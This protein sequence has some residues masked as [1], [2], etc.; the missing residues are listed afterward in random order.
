LANGVTGE[1]RND[2]GR[3]HLWPRAR[4]GR[5]LIL[6]LIGGDGKLNIDHLGRRGSRALPPLAPAQTTRVRSAVCG[7][8]TRVV[9]TV[10]L[11]VIV[12]GSI[13]AQPE[14]YMEPSGHE[15]LLQLSHAQAQSCAVR[16]SLPVRIIDASVPMTDDLTNYEGAIASGAKALQRQS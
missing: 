10:G 9:P 5:P 3:T 8:R 12:D 1:L 2:V 13:Q 15:T 6:L 16:P 11:N 14:I 4:R 7:L